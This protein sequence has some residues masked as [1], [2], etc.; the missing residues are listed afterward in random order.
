[1]PLRPCDHLAC[2]C[3]DPMSINAPCLS[4]VLVLFIASVAPAQ[5]AEQGGSSPQ[6]ET[7]EIEPYTGPPIFLPKV[8]PPPPPKEVESRTIKEKFPDSETVRFERRVVKYSDNSILSD[9]PHKEYYSSGQLYVEGEFD[10]GKAAGTWTYYHANGTVAKEVTYKQGKPDGELLI[11]SEEGKL[12]AKR[13]Y[14]LGRRAGT[15]DTY[16][17][18]GTQK[19]RQENYQDGKA[20]GEFKVWFASGQLRQQMTFD[21]GKREG[22][23][24]EWTSTGEKRA[25]INYRDGKRNG[26]ATVWGRDGKVTEQVYEDDRVVST[27]R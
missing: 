10:K 21:D 23:A 18:D 24:R 13:E 7:V 15:W 27:P 8:T 19:I 4:L 25:E 16:T 20:N 3:V 26:K 12:V 14:T 6:R 17:S 5:Q 9:G 2:Y 1:M 11:Y 22:I